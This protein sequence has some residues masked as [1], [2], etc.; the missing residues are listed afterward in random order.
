MFSS[1]SYFHPDRSDASSPRA[2]AAL[3]NRDGSELYAGGGEVWTILASS[4]QGIKSLPAAFPLRRIHRDW[5]RRLP[6]PSLEEHKPIVTMRARH[7]SPTPCYR[8][9][10]DAACPHAGM[11]MKS[12]VR[13]EPVKNSQNVEIL[14]IVSL[15]IFPDIF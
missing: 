1:P 10:F 3:T 2:P 6:C 11:C 12:K 5:W 14:P 8:C 9:R 4:V 13:L 7:P 15:H